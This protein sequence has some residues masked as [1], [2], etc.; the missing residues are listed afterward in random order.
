MYFYQFAKAIPI[1][2]AENAK[3]MQFIQYVV[4]INVF[5]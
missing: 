5:C 3:F 1:F 4:F 2:L